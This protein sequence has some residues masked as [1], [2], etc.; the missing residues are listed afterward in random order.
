[1]NNLS[2]P[3]P[4]LGAKGRP[5]PA[6]RSG[7]IMVFSLGLLALLSLFGL[8]AYSNATLE[9][10]IASN[11]LLSTE[12]LYN[13][14]AGVQIVRRTVEKQL[15][16]GKQL[17]EVIAN[18]SVTAPAG[19][20][21]DPVNSFHVLVPN[22]IFGFTVT[23]RSGDASAEVTSYFRRDRKIDVG[24]FGDR[25]F[26]T[27]PNFEVY[28]YNSK[29]ITNPT[30]DQSTGL[31][32][33]GSNQTVAL[34]NNGVVDGLVLLGATA[35]G[36]PATCN[37]CGLYDS[38]EIGHQDPDPLGANGGY[39]KSLFDFYSSNANND[40]NKTTLISKGELS[41]R[42]NTTVGVL[43]S[44]NYYVSS[45]N[46]Q[47]NRTLQIDA[48]NGPVR[49]YLTGSFTMGPSSSL[50]NDNPNNFQVFCLTNQ[51]IK[52][53][54]SGN[55]GMAV[56]APNAS[57]TMQPMGNFM[58]IVWAKELDMKPNEYVWVDTSLLDRYISNNLY[59]HSWNERRNQ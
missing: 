21:F 58:G 4:P 56:Y 51:D 52:I 53:Q 30:P 10:R 44:G 28:S 36:T 5:S 18:L 40:N 50:I 57:V 42:G 31:A 59:T 7:Y 9:S 22:V 54:P 1:M 23:G 6:S 49:I 29:L 25:L 27:Q 20:T 41:V 26:N 45:I 16:L 14:E 17:S 13:A 11:Q 32:S 8:V 24:F 48:S 2:D 38:L 39:L 34:G 33:I 15:G 12:A 47:N 37:N 3:R 35:A 55:V 19:I 46:M 43:K